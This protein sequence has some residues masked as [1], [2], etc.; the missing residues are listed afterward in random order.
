MVADRYTD[1]DRERGV[2]ERLT[3]KQYRWATSSE[4][5]SEKPVSS[6][7]NGCHLALLGR[8]FVQ[9]EERM[10]PCWQASQQVNTARDRQ[11]DGSCSCINRSV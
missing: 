5:E 6:S 11:R 10:Q 4:S 9:R 7:L 8:S 1:S 3:E 2:S